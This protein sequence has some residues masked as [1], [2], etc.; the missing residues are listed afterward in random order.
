VPLAEV[1]VVSNR[2]PVSFAKDAAGGLSPRQGAG[3]LA[4]SLAP[5]LE[6][7]GATWVAAAVGEADRLAARSGAL[8]AEGQRLGIRLVSPEV[9]PATYRM[10]YDVVANATLW[11]VHH[12]LF[13]LA[14]RPRFDRRFS[15][16]WAAYVAFNRRFA[17]AV[18]QVAPQGASVLVQDYHLALAGSYLAESRPDLACVHFSHTPFAGPDAWRVLPDA[19]AH[20][21]LEGMAACRARGFHSGRWASS[22][23]RCAQAVLGREPT[24]F[25]A[26]LGPD[27]EHLERVAG[28]QEARR[29]AARLE[30]LVGDRA[31]LLRVDRVEPSKNLL[32]GFLAFDELLESQPRWRGRVVFVALAYPSREGLADYLAYRT[33]VENLAEQLNDRWARGDWQPVVLEVDDNYPRSVAAL[34]RYDALLVNPVRDGLNLVAK[35]GAVLN[36]RRGVVALSREAGAWDELQG[37]ALEL[38]PFDVAMTAQAIRH[39]LEMPEDER[40]RRAEHLAALASARSP[41][42]WLDDQLR[43]ARARPG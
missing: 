9:E 20:S 33:E 8:A 36:R 15:D 26:T 40:A 4:S 34:A 41:R 3:G 22:F 2:G 10:A 35:E 24:T 19:A 21:V 6:G 39:A 14:R 25:V 30:E 12:G 1:V 27:A 42:H 11:Y 37:A 38:N 29:E 16:A 7:S 13:D 43:A 17:E 5:L 32:R 23:R 18:A 28:S 31:M